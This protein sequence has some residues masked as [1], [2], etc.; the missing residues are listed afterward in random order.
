MAQDDA[1]GVL[2]EMLREA[3]DSTRLS[4]RDVEDR[5]GIGHGMLKRLLDGSVELR[6]QHL[7]D[8]ARLL[9][10]DPRELVA[11]DKPDWQ[12]RYRL[13][14]WMSPQLRQTMGAAQ[15][16]MLSEEMSEAVRAIVREELARQGFLQKTAASAPKKE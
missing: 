12:V 8:F 4:A 15:P 11:L 5:L 13:V 7:T 6:L 14:D 2:R 10:I 9:E 1:F 3:L 16:M